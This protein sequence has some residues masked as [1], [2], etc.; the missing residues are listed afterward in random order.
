MPRDKKLPQNRLITS[1][2]VAEMLAVTP[3][4]LCRWRRE[5]TGPPFVRLHRRQRAIVR[6]RADD[7]E[8]Y[9]DDLRRQPAAESEVDHV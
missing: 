5:G 7:I 9:L 6:Y 3:A 2:I 4:T 1:A 8:K